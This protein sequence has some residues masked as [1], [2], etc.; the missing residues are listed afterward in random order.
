VVT[1]AKLN[2]PVAADAFEIKF[3]PGTRVYDWFA[4]REYYVAEAEEKAPEATTGETS[5]KAM[6]K[7]VED[8]RKETAQPPKAPAAPKPAPQP[9][10]GAHKPAAP[11]VQ[12]VA[13]PSRQISPWLIVGAGALVILI[14]AAIALSRRKAAG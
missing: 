8:V 13:A 7:F 2:Q 5:A 11:P 1:A 6:D 12:A 14:V 9:V 3:P 4:E 10:A